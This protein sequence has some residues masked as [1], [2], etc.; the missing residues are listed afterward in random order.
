[1]KSIWNKVYNI[2]ALLND[3]FKDTFEQ[4]HVQE[5]LKEAGLEAFLSDLNIHNV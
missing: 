4:K 3:P 2:E 5:M 1:M